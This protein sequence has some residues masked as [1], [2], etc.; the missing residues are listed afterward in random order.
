[1]RKD[2]AYWRDAFDNKWVKALRT[3]KSDL[4][5]MLFVFLLFV[6]ML[7]DF[8]YLNDCLS[9]LRTAFPFWSER[10]AIYILS[11]ILFFEA[12]FFLIFGAMFAGV[13]LYLAWSPGWMALF[14]D[15]VFHWK[16]VK[17]EREIPASLVAGLII[18][19]VGVVYILAAILVT[20]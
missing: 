4:W 1:M 7:I 16:I 13:V 5:W 12:G 8:V 2:H 17:K 6:P 9:I 18:I 14:V 10:S 15:P 19:A 3:L 20:L 11:D